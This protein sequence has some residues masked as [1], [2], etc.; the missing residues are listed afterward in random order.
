[1]E[2]DFVILVVDDSR[3]NRMALTKSLSKE[4]YALFEAESA[5]AALTFIS[6]RKPDLILLDIVMPEMSGFDLCRLLKQQSATHEIPIIF[7]TSLD[8]PEDKIKG[9]ELGAVDFITKPFDTAEIL[10]R[11]RTQV[12]L[13]QMYRT[14][15]ETNQRIERD[16]ATARHI[17]HNL[18][19]KASC[20]LTGNLEFEYAYIP[21]DE[22]G[23]DF[24]DIYQ[25]DGEHIV[26]YI[27]DVSGHGVASSLITIFTKFFFSL[28]A[29]TARDPAKL[30]DMLNRQFFQERFTEKYITVFLGILNLSQGQL[31][32][33]SAGQ[34]VAPILYTADEEH[35]LSMHSFPIGLLEQVTYTSATCDFN[36]GTSLLMYTDGV[37]DIQIGD[38]IPIF[39]EASLLQYIHT[40]KYSDNQHMVSSLLS[41]INQR[42]RKEDFPDDITIFLLRRGMGEDSR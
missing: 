5:D 32:W 26:F 20:F 14:L 37:T 6:H 38:G 25:I 39:E 10:A 22:L 33:S 19:P 1:M 36:P 11:V 34:S 8:T 7:I 15:L 30:L 12:E 40:H 18:L 4:H 2:R 42:A 9:L 3:I 27:L 35:L 41:Y 24:F 29:K 13:Q 28:H 31:T 16:L 17:Q 21:C 23:G